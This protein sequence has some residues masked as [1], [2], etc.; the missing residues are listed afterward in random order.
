MAEECRRVNDGFD[1][2]PILFNENSIENLYPKERLVYLSPN[3][4]EILTEMNENEIYVIGGLV[5]E[6]VRKV[7]TFDSKFKYVFSSF[8]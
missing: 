8:Y 3:A 7:N 5:D 4:D 6:S 1:Q 2:Y